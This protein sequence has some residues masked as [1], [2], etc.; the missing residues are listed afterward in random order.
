VVGSVAPSLGLYAEQLRLAYAAGIEAYRALLSR[1]APAADDLDRPV[2]G[3]PRFA[4]FVAEASN[5]FGVPERWIRAVMQVES[6][7]EAGATS[8]KGAMG[9]MQVM[10][11]TFA[12]LRDRYGL[13]D[14]PYAPRDNI[15]AGGAYIREM[16]DRY[17]S[18]GFI[19]AYNAGPA[20]Y[21]AFLALGQQLP[22][23]TLRY[24][25]AVGQ[26]L[27]EDFNGKVFGVLPP[28][29]RMPRFREPLEVSADGQL[30][31]R[32]T[33]E[34]VTVTDRLALHSLLARAVGLPAGR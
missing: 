33:G 5:R 32:R 18:P 10:P 15:L 8:P 11:T 24:V 12:N 23:E 14:N 6:G 9:L 2:D 7:G 26:A 27:G 13:G 31:L 22:E 1:R 17:G 4:A 3:N 20:R 30:L 19:A 16:Y 34:P 28:P 25:S 29:L 21:D